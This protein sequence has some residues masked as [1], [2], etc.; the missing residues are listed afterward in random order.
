M[1]KNRRESK[2]LHFL[3]IAYMQ[4]ALPVLEN[5][6]SS[7][8]GHRSPTCVP[9]S[10]TDSVF[11]E[12]PWLPSYLG[13]IAELLKHS[14]IWKRRLAAGDVRSTSFRSWPR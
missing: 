6:S 3:M 5:S 12:I 1:Q 11:Q 13:L 2:K 4:R 7:A 9:S 10:L 8:T 14:L